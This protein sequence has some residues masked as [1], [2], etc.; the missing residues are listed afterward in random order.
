MTV[1]ELITLLE[2]MPDDAEV[3]IAVQPRYPFEKSIEQVVGV[4]VDGEAKV[5]I[6]EGSQIGYLPGEVSTELGWR[7]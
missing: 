1:L 6:G 3:R 4:E 2:D 5:Y 7:A